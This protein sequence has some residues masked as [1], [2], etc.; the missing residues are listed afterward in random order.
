MRLWALLILCVLSV[1]PAAQAK[2]LR[3]TVDDLIEHTR[4]LEGKTA[5]LGDASHGDIQSAKNQL[6]QLT[7]YISELSSDRRTIDG[8]DKVLR[9]YENDA[10]RILDS[11]QILDR[12]ASNAHKIEPSINECKKN[13]RDLT[14]SLQLVI[15]REGNDLDDVEKVAKQIGIK[16]E[17]LLDASSDHIDDLDDGLRDLG[18]SLPRNRD[19]SRVAANL[20]DSGN[21]IFTREHR[22]AEQV[23]DACADLVDY[24]DHPGY[25][26]AKEYFEDRDGAIARYLDDGKDWMALHSDIGDRM[27]TFGQKIREAYCALD[28]GAID[29]D[30][31]VEAYNRE[32]TSGSNRFRKMIDDAVDLYELDLAHVG[33]NLENE[34]PDVERLYARM[35]KRASYYY[36]LQRANEFRNMANAADRL[37]I[38]Y[39]QQQHQRIQG[40]GFCHVVEKYIPGASPRMRVDC[41]EISKCTVWEIKSDSSGN[42]SRGRSQ[43]ADYAKS[44]NSWME[45]VAKRTEI[46][47]A[48]GSPRKGMTFDEDFLAYAA[49]SNCLVEGRG[50]FEGDLLTYPRC[51]NDLDLLCEPQPK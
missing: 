36:R 33:A 5:R 16:A 50:Y 35:R 14:R 38:V 48:N 12:M 9:D 10:R 44:I 40:N 29:A 51:R 15:E 24:K 20:S 41:V 8:L 1:A 11:L 30:R 18:R 22:F 3:D 32:I 47:P 34:D 26:A 37:W 4:R 31:L 23:I 46:K 7:K 6:S 49:A 45:G 42:Q 13:Q 39:G 25:K 17:A 27:C 43:A 19:F 21:E 28:P 2:T